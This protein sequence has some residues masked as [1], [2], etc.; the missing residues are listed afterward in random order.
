MNGS[1]LRSRTC[2]AFYLC[3]CTTAGLRP[4]MGCRRTRTRSRT[5]VWG[6]VLVAGLLLLFAWGWLLMGPLKL[7]GLSLLLLSGLFS[8]MIVRAPLWPGL[9][10]PLVPTIGYDGPALDGLASTWD[11]RNGR[12]EPIPDERP[13]AIRVSPN[14]IVRAAESS[15][16]PPSPQQHRRPRCLGIPRKERPLAPGRS[17]YPLSTDP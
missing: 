7:V 14:S 3:A 1:G 12:A 5:T 16:T 2:R 11:R 13:D 4:S 10:M 6:S 17:P 9:L 15:A 8:V